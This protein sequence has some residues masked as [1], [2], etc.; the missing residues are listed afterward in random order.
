[1]AASRRSRGERTPG[2]RSLSGLAYNG[3]GATWILTGDFAKNGR[4]QRGLV[5]TALLLHGS[6][7]LGGFSSGQLALGRVKT[8]SLESRRARRG[9]D[10]AWDDAKPLGK[11][12]V[13]GSS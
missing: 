6:P 4:T 7:R 2:V 11:G 1:M 9:H 13:L 3:V 5:T 8:V 12:N 10:G